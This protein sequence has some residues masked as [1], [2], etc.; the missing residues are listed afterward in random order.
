MGALLEIWVEGV[1]TIGTAGSFFATGF[2]FT[3]G[4]DTT[5]PVR[6]IR[7][8]GSADGAVGGLAVAAGALGGFLSACAAAFF[9]GF[10]AI[11][12]V[13]VDRPSCFGV[14]RADAL[15]F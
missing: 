13:A 12:P 14:M 11:I 3:T 7:A 10:S 9:A 1:W 8:A 15:K 4:V 6:L 2:F 5:E